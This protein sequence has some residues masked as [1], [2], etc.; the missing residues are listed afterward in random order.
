MARPIKN[1]DKNTFEQLCAIQCTQQEICDV[2]NIDHKTLTAWC[3]RTYNNDYSQVYKQYS[4]KGKMTLR[5]YQFKLAEKYPA[6]AIFLGKQMLGQK[7]SV[8]IET[9]ETQEKHEEKLMEAL[10]TRNIEGVDDGNAL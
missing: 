9:T 7:D 4:S 10:V 5:R 6:M 1:I 3:K 8:N 2:L